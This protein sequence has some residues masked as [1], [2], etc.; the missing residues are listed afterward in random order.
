MLIEQ[1]APR[2]CP[3]PQVLPCCLTCTQQAGASRWIVDTAQHND[4]TYGCR[5]ELRES[6]SSDAGS[7]S[8]PPSQRSGAA[9]AEDEDSLLRGVQAAQG[10]SP[11]V[12]AALFSQLMEQARALPPVTPR[13][14]LHT[15]L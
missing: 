9:A 2:H 13:L 15:C 8:P 10:P 5:P 14:L 6:G 3:L 7:P 1:S 4:C 12:D 11:V